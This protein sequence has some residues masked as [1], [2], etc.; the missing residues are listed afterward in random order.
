MHTGKRCHATEHVDLMSVHIAMECPQVERVVNADGEPLTM[1]EALA[2]K[3]ILGHAYVNSVRCADCNKPVEIK[4]TDKNVCYAHTVP[5]EG[6]R[7]MDVPSIVHKAAMDRLVSEINKVGGVLLNPV[8]CKCRY[9]LAPDMPS[10]EYVHSRAYCSTKI[11]ALGALRHKYLLDI[12]IFSA[13]KRIAVLQM[14]RPGKLLSEV[15]FD[16]IRQQYKLAVHEV[17]PN[18][19]YDLKDFTRTTSG[20][21]VLRYILRNYTCLDCLNS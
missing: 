12:G 6:N 13:G 2:L 3:I 8:C 20:M 5:F 11:T 4:T 1:Q 14:A 16:D 21:P 7:K 9:N 10:T 17:V 19:V 18:D 15:A